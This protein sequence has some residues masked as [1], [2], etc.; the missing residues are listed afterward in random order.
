MSLP[1]P[2]LLH[3]CG[4]P[5]F[6]GVVL[7]LCPLQPLDEVSINIGSAFHTL[8]GTQFVPLVPHLV[9]LRP[10]SSQNLYLG[11]PSLQMTTLSSHRAPDTTMFFPRI[12][13]VTRV[14][15]HSSAAGSIH[16]P[17]NT[18]VPTYPQM[19]FDMCPLTH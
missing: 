18:S 9:T 4:S 17:S 8:L 14:T 19:S 10:E 11:P 7:G 1:P 15:L 12:I 13:H 5:G 3:A 6:T 2:T 16:A